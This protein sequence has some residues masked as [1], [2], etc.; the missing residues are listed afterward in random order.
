[1]STTPSDPTNI[2]VFDI[3][4]QRSFDE[5]GG[6]DHFDKLGVSYVGVYSYRTQQMHGFFEQDLPLLEQI[7]VAERPMLVGFNSI[8]FDN[9]VLQPYFS[10]ID[11]SSLPHLDMLKEVEKILGHRIKLDNLAQ[12]TLHMGKSASGLDAIRWFREGNLE[13]LAKYCLDDVQVTR[14]LYEY[15]QRHGRIH[16]PSGGQIMQVAA[17]W[18]VPPTIRELLESAWKEH[19]QI[20]VDYIEGADQSRIIKRYTWEIQDL[21]G[22]Q[23]T[24]YCQETHATGSYD[25]QRVWLVSDQGQNFSHQAKLF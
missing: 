4:T 21:V 14:D 12:A 18:A 8:H 2:V 16:Y 11:L 13:A 20:I 17:S 1:M 10:Q 19:R 9:P 5:V 23:L 24:A 25:A 7:L 6:Y 22:D 3:E 15:G